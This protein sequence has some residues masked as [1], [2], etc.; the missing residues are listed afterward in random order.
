MNYNMPKP[1][2]HNISLIFNIGTPNLCFECLS[3][4]G[5]DTPM[6]RCDQFSLVLEKRGVGLLLAVGVLAN[7]TLLTFRYFVLENYLTYFTQK[8]GHILHQRLKMN[9]KRCFV[10]RFTHIFIVT[11][12]LAILV[13]NIEL[14][15]QTENAAWQSHTMLEAEEH[16][17]SNWIKLLKDCRFESVAKKVYFFKYG[18]NRCC[19]FCCCLTGKL[20]NRRKKN[21]AISSATQKQ[22]ESMF[23]FSFYQNFHFNGHL[24]S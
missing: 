23:C 9:T 2:P 13:L 24:W 5:E 18:F 19:H 17:L 16:N 15:K 12:F 21:T 6:P 7:S 20:C 8:N 14:K 22:Y 1:W 10:F 3:S 11:A 4:S